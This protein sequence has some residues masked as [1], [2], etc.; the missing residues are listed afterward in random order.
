MLYVNM[1]LYVRLKPYKHEIIR[2][3]CCNDFFLLE[4]AWKKIIPIFLLCKLR[5]I[6]LCISTYFINLIYADFDTLYV[7]VEIV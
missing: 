2:S 6:S 4:P 1:N 5:I 3:C 7:S